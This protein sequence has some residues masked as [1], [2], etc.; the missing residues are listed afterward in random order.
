M[1]N[2]GA[3]SHSLNIAR[4]NHRSVS[5]AVAMFQRAF[6]NVSNDFHVAVCMSGKAAA[7]VHKVF[8]NDAQTTKTYESG[9][10]VVAKRK[11]VKG[12]QPAKV[13]MAAPVGLAYLDHSKYL[14]LRLPNPSPRDSLRFKAG[15]RDKDFHQLIQPSRIVI[16]EP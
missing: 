8:V 11:R 2:P 12:V 3:G 1:R 13:E 16:I 14:P 5:H 10:V 9:I 15:R 7:G 6:K 4:A